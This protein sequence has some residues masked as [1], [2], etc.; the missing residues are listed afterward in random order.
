MMSSSKG[1]FGAGFIN[2]SGGVRNFPY[3]SVDVV[4]NYLVSFSHQ[5]VVNQLILVSKLC[6][7]N[8]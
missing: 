6:M 5:L 4:A 3:E 8:C 7:R 2:Q 1:K